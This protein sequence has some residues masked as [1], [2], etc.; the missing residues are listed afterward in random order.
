MSPVFIIAML[1]SA[2]LAI[3]LAMLWGM[4]RLSRRRHPS[5]RTA[6]PDKVSHAGRHVHG[7]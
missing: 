2:W 1:V 7:H 4:L 3:C 5:T 6:K